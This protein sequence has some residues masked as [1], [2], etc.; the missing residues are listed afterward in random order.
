[1]FSPANLKSKFANVVPAVN[2]I[3]IF[4][5]KRLIY[6]TISSLDILYTH[7]KNLI[8]CHMC[9]KCPWNAL[10][11]IAFVSYLL[12][13]GNTQAVCDTEGTAMFAEI[14]IFLVQ[15]IMSHENGPFGKM[16]GPRN[17]IIR[18]TAK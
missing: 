7:Y 17:L 16:M 1:M 5:C 9:P 12:E 6:T 4:F 10:Y 15:N 2:N 3:K 8:Q 11:F 14:Y 18:L 13:F